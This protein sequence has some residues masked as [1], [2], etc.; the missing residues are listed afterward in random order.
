MSSAV[1]DRKLTNAELDDLLAIVRTPGP[2]RLMIRGT[3]VPFVPPTPGQYLKYVVARFQ[4]PRAFYV[5]TA[6]M[7]AARKAIETAE[8]EGREPSP[9]D[10]MI[11]D[12]ESYM[13]ANATDQADADA[14]VLAIALERPGDE[15][16]EASLLALD[17]EEFEANLRKVEKS[18]WGEDPARFFGV[19]ARKLAGRTLQTLTAAR[20][21]SKA[22]TE[23]SSKPS[24]T[25]RTPSPSKAKTKPRSSKSAT[26]G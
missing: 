6:Q 24:T 23:K 20:T 9:D 11:V 15:K 7:E 14:A 10:L 22:T 3:P 16:T 17:D 4:A 8:Q 18:M 12:T 5:M 2:E 19:V 26:R 21:A 1:S 25:S 13:V